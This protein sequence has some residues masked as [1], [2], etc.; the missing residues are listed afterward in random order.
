MTSIPTITDRTP[1]GIIAQPPLR[2]NSQRLLTDKSSESAEL[3]VAATAPESRGVTAATGASAGAR[4]EGVAR[5]TS[6]RKGE[7]VEC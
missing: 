2:N 5:E 3:L 7:L 1:R 6:G 4:E